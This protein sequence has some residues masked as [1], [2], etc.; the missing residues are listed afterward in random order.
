MLSK[1]VNIF[2][3]CDEITEFVGFSFIFQGKLND[4]SGNCWV[5]VGLVDFVDDFVGGIGVK[6]LDVDADV[7]AVFDFEL[8]VFLDDRIIAITNNEELGFG[9]ERLYLMR[10]AFFDEAS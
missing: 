10:L 4:D 1:A 2:I 7:F 5:N 3:G 6:I 8:N 9:I